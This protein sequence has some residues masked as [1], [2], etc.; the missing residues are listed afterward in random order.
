M[1]KP[2]LSVAR[3]VGIKGQAFLVPL[4][5]SQITLLPGP[6][7]QEKEQGFVGD[8]DHPWPRSSPPKPPKTLEPPALTLQL[9]SHRHPGT[10]KLR[11]GFPVTGSPRKKDR[12]GIMGSLRLVVQCQSGQWLVSAQGWPRLSSEY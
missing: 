8:L 11:A 4:S 12:Q 2:L 9:L 10:P 3:L 6:P 1:P 5:I 7:P